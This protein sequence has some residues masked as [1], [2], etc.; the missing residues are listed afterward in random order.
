MHSVLKQGLRLLV[1]VAAVASTAQADPYVRQRIDVQ[2][3]RFAITLADSTDRISGDATIRFAVLQADLT[4]VWLD[5]A[6]VTPARQGRG[7]RVSGVTRDGSPLVFRHDGDRLTISLDRPA[8][9]GSVVELL[10]HYAGIP[11]DGL[12][13]KPTPLGDRAFFSDNWPDKGHHWLPLI[14]HI[15]DKATMEMSVTAPS[16]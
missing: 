9:I 8:A 4:Q 6:G 13:I 2:H 5:L 10:V 11:A 3:Y 14:D 12:Q 7:M 15:A 16:H 1:M